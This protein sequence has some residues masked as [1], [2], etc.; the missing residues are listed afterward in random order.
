MMKRCVAEG[1]LSASFLSLRSGAVYFDCIYGSIDAFH[2]LRF[3]TIA[4]A[5]Q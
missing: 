1:K 2:N 5:S 3:L 4:L